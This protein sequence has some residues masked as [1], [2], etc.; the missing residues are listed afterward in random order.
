MAVS[1]SWPDEEDQRLCLEFMTEFPTEGP[2]LCYLFGAYRGRGVAREY[3]AELV[4][5]LMPRDPE[6]A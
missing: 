1:R 2:G 6:K 5:L 3:A 4:R